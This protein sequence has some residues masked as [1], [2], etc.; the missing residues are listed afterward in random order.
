MEIPLLAK[1]TECCKNKEM[2]IV[3]HLLVKYTP[4][5]YPQHNAKMNNY[6]IQKHQ[7][8]SPEVNKLEK[9]QFNST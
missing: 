8:T 6:F 4:A 2:W 9:M 5:F 3:F 1:P 7:Q